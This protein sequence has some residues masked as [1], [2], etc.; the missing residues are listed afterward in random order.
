MND[1]ILFNSL[2]FLYNTKFCLHTGHCLV[3][4]L[5][6]VS[7]QDLHKKHLVHLQILN[8]RFL[9][10]SQHITQTLCNDDTDILHL[11]TNSNL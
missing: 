3:P 8:K 9:V 1:T 4:L 11:T 7:I 10:S 6:N 2:Y 5:F